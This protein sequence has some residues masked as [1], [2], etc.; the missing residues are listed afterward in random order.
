MHSHM[1]VKMTK[2]VV[3]FC[4]FSKAPNKMCGVLNLSRGTRTNQFMAFH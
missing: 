1:N 3:G 2:L 4:S